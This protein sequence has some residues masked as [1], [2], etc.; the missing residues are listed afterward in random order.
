[1][2]TEE[3]TERVPTMGVLDDRLVFTTNFGYSNISSSRI[4]GAELSIAGIERA[5]RFL[6]MASSERSMEP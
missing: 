3:K 4:N 2:S 1:M 5:R 6:A